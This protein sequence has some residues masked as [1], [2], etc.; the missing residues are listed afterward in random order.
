MA[1]MGRGVSTAVG[2]A[3]ALGIQLV[4]FA[5]TAPAEVS[6]CAPYP[7]Y[8]TARGVLQWKPSLVRPYDVAGVPLADRAPTSQPGMLVGLDNGAWS[9]WDQADLNAQGSHARGNVYN[10][11]QWPYVDR[12]YYYSHNLLSVP[13]TQWTNAAHRQGVKVLATLTGDC[14]DLECENQFDRLFARSP[15]ETVDQLQRI[16]AAYGF[17]GWMI[18]IEE[19]SSFKPNLLAAMSDLSKRRLPG[20]ARVDVAFYNAGQTT[21][22]SRMYQALRAAGLWQSDYTPGDGAVDDPKQSYDFLAA[23]G[24]AALADDTYWSSY[25]YSYETGSSQ[26]GG[27]TSADFLWNGNKCLDR[28][29]LFKNQGSALAP[30]DPPG[31]YQAPS[32]Y[33]T[34]WTLFG[35]LK[36]TTDKLPNRGKFRQTDA[37]LWQGPGYVD[38]GGRCVPADRSSNAVSSMV[39]PRPAIA[40]VP[41]VTRFDSGEGSSFSAQGKV[42]RDAGWNL[43]SAQDPLPVAWC[44]DGGTLDAELDYKTAYDGG[45]SLRV[46]GRARDGSRRVYLYGAHARLPA[47]PGF[48]LR[49][50]AGHGAAPHVVLTL[51][52][53]GRPVDIATHRST[54]H[55]KWVLA[56]GTLPKR[57]A[58]AVLTRVGVGFGHHGRHA[59]KVNANIGELRIVDRARLGRPAQITPTRN[60]QNLSWAPAPGAILYYD[61]W[62]REPTRSCLSFIGRTQITRYDL[63]N[64]LFGPAP[65]SGRYEVQ[66]VSTTGAGAKLSGPRC[67][68]S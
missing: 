2:L 28:S 61:V 62:R 44:G 20:G 30:R 5:G 8:H 53:R 66:P 39:S 55:G 65:A 58:P 17:D 49:Y 64:P 31:R 16:A 24:Q 15:D 27:N 32:L 43:L 21:L 13:P 19:D 54:R 35:G 63:A 10:F 46:S 22:D 50:E 36:D 14:D 45:S 26:C 7:C 33:A 60:G 25:V 40:Q 4:A 41:F 9:Y 57:L 56:R 38:R 12:L 48:R 6:R 23:R 68:T 42:V 3:M 52:G 51:R 11:A 67:R 29:T 1:V 47:N 37:V 59:R 34:A 18:D